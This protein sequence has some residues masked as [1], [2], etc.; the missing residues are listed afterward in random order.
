MNVDM[1]PPTIARE[2]VKHVGGRR[3]TAVAVTITLVVNSDVVHGCKVVPDV[4][5]GELRGRREGG[6]KNVYRSYI[7]HKFCVHAP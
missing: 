4:T 1:H 7:L 6:F 2:E 5:E 3:P